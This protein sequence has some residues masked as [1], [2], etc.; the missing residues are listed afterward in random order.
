MGLGMKERHRLTDEIAQ[1]YRGA[2]AG[3]KR[4]I[5]DEFTATTG[6]N[7]KYASHLLSR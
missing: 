6:Y 5:L 1:R 2:S 7:R 4:S 3:K